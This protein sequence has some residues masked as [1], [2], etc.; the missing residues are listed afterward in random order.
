MS[1]LIYT[2]HLNK[3]TMF[4]EKTYKSC[5][6]LESSRTRTDFFL[7]FVC[8]LNSKSLIKDIVSEEALR[9]VTIVHAFN[10]AY[11]TLSEAQKILVNHSLW[12]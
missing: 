8:F 6:K 9:P 12:V 11:H 5:K 4:I 2:D 1:L 10:D 3:N 7:F